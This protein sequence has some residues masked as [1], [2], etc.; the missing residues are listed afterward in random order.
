MEKIIDFDGYNVAII[1]K[2][3]ENGN[4]LC[5]LQ[6]VDEN[7]ALGK[8][9]TDLLFWGDGYWP[10]ELSKEEFEELCSEP[11]INIPE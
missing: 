3:Y 10:F 6:F 9:D 5:D 8:N 11:N 4:C 7:G 1:K 2:L